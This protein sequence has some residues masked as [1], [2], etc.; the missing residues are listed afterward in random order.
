MV[1]RIDDAITALSGNGGIFIGTNQYTAVN[2]AIANAF[3]LNNFLWQGANFGFLDI[4]NLFQFIQIAAPPI[5]YVVFARRRP[6]VV[7]RPL[8]L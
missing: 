2:N 7:R 4:A 3:T 8:R 1:G 5:F 6:P